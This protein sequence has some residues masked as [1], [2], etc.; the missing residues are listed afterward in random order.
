MVM[1]NLTNGSGPKSEQHTNILLAL[2]IPNIVPPK[3]QSLLSVLILCGNS[4]SYQLW[5]NHIFAFNI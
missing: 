2:Y 3:R 4:I 5:D 1:N